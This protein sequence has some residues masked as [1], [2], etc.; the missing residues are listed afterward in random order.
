MIAITKK[1]AEQ[2]NRMRAALIQI[3]KEY[4]TPVQL[5]RNSGKQYGLDYEEVLEMSYEN[6]QDEAKLASK[7]VKAL[8]TD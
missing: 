3:A 4:Q 7:G 1:Q 8:K 6:I 2:F 5:K